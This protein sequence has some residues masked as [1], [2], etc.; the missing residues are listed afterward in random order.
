MPIIIEIE[1]VTTLIETINQLPDYIGKG[2]MQLLVIT[3]GGIVV[4]WISTWLFG[5][6]SEINAVEGALLKRKL[7]IYEELSAK[8]E[9]LKAM[10]I[11]PSDIHDAAMRQLKNEGIEFNPINSNQLLSIFDAPRSLTEEFLGIDN[12]ISSKRLY[13]DDDVLIQT[14]RFQNYFACFRRFLV[15][16][17]EQFVDAGLSLDK[18]EVAAAER[19]LS[20]ELGMMLQDELVEQMDKLIATMKLSFKNLSFNYRDGIAFT[21]DFFNSPEGPIMS[22]LM[23]TKLLLKKEEINKVITN[24]IAQGMAACVVPH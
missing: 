22:E 15:M 18:E 7:D 1:F 17:E 4:A 13:F 21:Y 14:L 5:R 2:I 12:Y 10:V 8:L 20:V 9:S 23:K 19:L 16:F 24:A 11:I 3:L 6:K